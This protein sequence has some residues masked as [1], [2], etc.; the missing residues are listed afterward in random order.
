VPWSVGGAGG[1]GTDYRT[2]SDALV[3]TS[4]NPGWVTFDVTSRVQQWGTSGAN[5]GW[6]LAQTTAGINSKTFNASEYTADATLRPKLT[7]I[8]Q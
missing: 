7:V 8:Y 3:T 2:T 4:W 1:A 6:R 5:Y